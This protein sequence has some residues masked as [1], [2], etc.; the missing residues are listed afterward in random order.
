[1][2]RQLVKSISKREWWFLVVTAVFLIVLTT[3]PYV[4]GW[5]KAPAGSTYTGLHS[6]TPGDIHVHFSYLE[7]VRQGQLVFQDLYSGEPQ[8]RLIFNGFWSALGVF[9]VA[10][11]LSNVVAF[12]LARI[13]F[14]PFLLFVSYLLSAYFFSAKGWRRIC[15]IFLT[16]ASGLGAVFSPLLTNNVYRQGW[17]NWPLDLWAAEN[18]NLLTMLQSPHLSLA[19]SLI[20]LI[21]FLFF[22]AVEHDRPKYSLAAGL[23]AL[24]LFEFHPFHIPATIAIMVVYLA[25]LFI[26]NKKIQLNY[27]KHLLIVIGV[28]SPSILYYYLLS[29]YDFFTQIRVYQNVCLSPALWVTFISYGLV[30]ALAVYAVYK[31][32]KAGSP[33]NRHVFLIIW[34]VVQ[35]LFLYS[36]LPWQR[37]MMQGLQIPM[38][39]L[40]IIGLESLFHWLKAKMSAHNFDFFINNKYLAVI[41]FIAVF[42][43]SQVFNWVREF[44][45]FQT[46]RYYE[47]LYI[48]RDRLSAYLWLKDNLGENDVVLAELLNGNLI[49][50][51]A[52][53]KVFA[54]HGVETLFF[55]SKVSDIAWFF[56]TNNLDDKKKVFLEKNNV[57]HIFFGEREASLGDFDP[58]D[59][60]YLRPVFRSGQVV[61]FQVS[62]H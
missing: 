27:L 54:G 15:F 3:A 4:F 35:F 29:R 30:L 22:L 43:P 11:G 62:L 52:G 32:I 58:T 8:S 57:S 60:N 9:A 10:F 26:K 16:Y 18:N 51:V 56:K 31:I 28:S 33:A 39:I 19:S 20:I 36:P 42:C 24:I 37:R 49:P 46:D 17:Y 7:Q 47:Q 6:L 25:Y 34:L 55:D 45:I 12:Q 44:S 38:T 13:I 53:R 41:I 2:L 14:I 23:L 5:H 21:L 50:G 40:A 1:M 61:I 48:P 59:K